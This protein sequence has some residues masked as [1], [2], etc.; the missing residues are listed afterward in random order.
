MPTP[1]P[2]DHLRLPRSSH[3]P[4]LEKQWRRDHPTCAACGKKT[5][6]QVH[7]KI[8]VHVSRSQELD[9]S[10]LIT[11]CENSKDKEGDQHCHLVIGHL[12]NWY[13]YN[14]NVERDAAVALLT[15]YPKMVGNH[16]VQGRTGIDV[17]P[18]APPATPNGKPPAMAAE[19]TAVEVPPARTAH[20]RRRR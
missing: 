3:W 9:P 18:E 8:P 10:N 15:N 19:G 11:L 12:G 4:E 14:K 5:N 16:Y 1:T 17:V 20:A 13:N 6:L 2:S 7:H